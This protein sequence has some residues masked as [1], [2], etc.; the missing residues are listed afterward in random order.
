MCRSSELTVLG[1]ASPR[2][3]FLYC[4]ILAGVLSSATLTP[5]QPG[6]NVVYAFPRPGERKG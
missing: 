6:E 3:G 4:S 2:R 5:G 1:E